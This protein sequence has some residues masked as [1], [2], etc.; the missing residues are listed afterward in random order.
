M[1]PFSQFYLPL[2][3]MLGDLDPNEIYQFQNSALDAAIRTVLLFGRAPA[4]YTLVG[5]RMNAVAI[6]PDIPNGND[7]AIISL[8]AALLLMGGDA[9]GIQYR[10]R[11]LWV[12]ESDDRKKDLVGKI[13]AEIY[14]IV[15][16]PGF[17][18][19]QNFLTWITSFNDLRE[20]IG[21][22]VKGPVTTLT[23]GNSV[24]PT[25]L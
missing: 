17:T 5:D 3:V 7:F 14:Q 24:F 4:T 22:D 25:V 19:Y 16:G 18:S 10:T 12:K 15:A 8:E 21:A 13:R 20:G 23:V 6:T 9:G 1:T 11:A 2:R